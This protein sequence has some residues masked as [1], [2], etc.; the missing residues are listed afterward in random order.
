MTKAEAFADF[1]A[2]ILPH[3]TPGDIPMRDQAWNDYTDG[4]QKDGQI[5]AKQYDT[6][7]SPFR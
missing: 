5:T 6:W 3:L 1:K 4:L 2:T 7:V